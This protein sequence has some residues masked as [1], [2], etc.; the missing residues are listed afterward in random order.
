[1]ASDTGSGTAGYNPTS[2]DFINRP[3]PVE[4]S[5][6]DPN[7]AFGSTH[8]LDKSA[9]DDLL[10][11]LLSADVRRPRRDAESARQSRSSG[12]QA[13][14]VPLALVLNGEDESSGTSE[15]HSTRRDL[16]QPIFRLPELPP[17]RGVKRARI[18]PPTLQGLHQPPPDA[19]LLPSISAEGAQVLVKATRDKPTES[20]STTQPG[21]TARDANS[22][23]AD[24]DAA[25]SRRVRRNK[26]SEEET[27]CLLKGVARFG[28]GSWKKILNCPDYSF[29]KRTAIDLK[30]SR[31]PAAQRFTEEADAYLLEGFN[32]YGAS[33]KSIQ[34]DTTLQLGD[35]Q[36]TDLRDRFRI[37]YPE[38][39]A[40]IGLASRPQSFPKPAKRSASTQAEEQSA[41]SKDVLVPENVVEPLKALHP[42]A[43]PVFDA[44]YLDDSAFAEDADDD[45][46][47]LDRS[48]VDWALGTSRLSGDNEG[49]VPFVDP[50]ATLS[51]PRLG[52]LLS[53]D[54]EP[55]DR[56]HIR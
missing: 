26:W 45:P 18:L 19:G 41:Q 6:L 46:V 5:A 20:A 15:H 36:P 23:A 33:W 42:P 2:L 28:I 24:A 47:T 31:P 12:A 9:N 40:D 1:M 25:S 7:L 27:A 39:Y 56:N 49:V 17:K 52:D 22:A 14:A 21:I 43:F 34:L 32:K 29:N 8:K 37:R 11:V 54:L 3:N 38:K 51:L 35:R 50:L 16:D 53:G 55:A 48:I 4:P 30:D 13:T 44:D 10:R